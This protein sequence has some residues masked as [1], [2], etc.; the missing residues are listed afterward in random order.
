MKI[1]IPYDDALEEVEFP[2]GTDMLEAG[3][4]PILNDDEIGEKIGRSFGAFAAYF[5]GRKVTVVVNDHT[6]R[7]PTWKILGCLMDLIPPERMEILVATGTHRAPRNEELK[8]ILGDS[9]D[10]FSGRIFY[11]DCRD[12][13]S[14]VDLGR[15][16]RGTPVAVNRRLFESEAVICINSVEPHFFAGFTGGRKSL[17]PGLASFE[18]TVANHFHAKFENARSLNL[19]D[20]PVHLDLEEAAAM[21][22]GMP[23]LSLQ[24]VASRRGDII[25][26]YGGDLKSS[27]IAA[28]RRAKQ[29]FSVSIDKYYDIVFAVGE[30][31]LDANLYQ[32][33]KAQE[34]G[35]EAVKKGGI[36]VVL[37][38][39]NEGTGSPYFV[40]DADLYPTP[41]SVLSE[42]AMEDERFGIHKLI[43]TARRLREIK[44]WY[45]TN[46]DDKV[47]RK[48]YF[49][50]KRSLRVALRDAL[51][52][53]GDPA[54]IAVLKDAC[55]LVPVAV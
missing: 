27:L 14:L 37:G 25:D 38:A 2:G 18:T 29:V 3:S 55:F 33:Q 32:L 23:I 54:T 52:A 44:I 9:A 21:I 12:M 53:K 4:Y 36:L 22:T 26:L 39:C 16:S 20:N 13:D 34:H 28:A 51:D 31:P 1:Q 45:V 30:P 50:P 11:H 17:V 19:D 5:E 49:E 48:L 40:E 41:E 7:L 42:K 10:V 35:A 43:K 24:L 46:L 47:I 8:G 6:R 15:T